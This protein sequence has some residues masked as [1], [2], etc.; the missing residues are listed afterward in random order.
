MPD[1]M[2]KC[3]PNKFDIFPLSRR[4]DVAIR[5]GD[6]IVALENYADRIL[7]FKENSLYIINI[8]R[9]AEFL[10]DTYRYKGISHPASVCKTDFGIAWVNR[11]GCFLYDGK[12]VK[13]LIEEGGL[14]KKLYILMNLSIFY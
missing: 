14:F 9:D 11:Y 13:N 4:V 6:N 5:D 3:V 12:Q 8:S 10:E 7:Q 2:L 1:T